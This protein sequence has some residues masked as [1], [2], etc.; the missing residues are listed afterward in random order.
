[1]SIFDRIYARKPNLVIGG[2]ENPY[3]RRWFVIPRNPVFNIYLHEIVRSDEDR[4]LHCHPWFNLSILL[5]GQYVEHTIRAGGI[6]RRITRRAGQ[7]KFRTPWGAHRLEIEP[8]TICRTLFLTGPRQRE[9]GFHCPAGWVHWLQLDHTGPK[10]MS[11]ADARSSIRRLKDEIERGKC[12]V[13]CAN[14]HAVKTAERRT[15]HAIGRVCE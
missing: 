10:S 14:C 6:N 9:W 4:A 12:V 7:W 5:E 8:G 15:E 2:D 3:L 11:I 1:M 13:R